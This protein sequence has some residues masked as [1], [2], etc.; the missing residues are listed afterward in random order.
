MTVMNV[1]PAERLVC[2]TVLGKYV[3]MAYDSCAH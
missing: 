2:S 3:K 1:V